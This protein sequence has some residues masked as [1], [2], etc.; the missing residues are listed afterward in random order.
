MDTRQTSVSRVKRLMNRVDKVREYMVTLQ[1]KWEELKEEAHGIAE[2]M[3][4]ELFDD[5]VS[6]IV[7]VPA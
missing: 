7:D 2:S 6:T 4:P 1:E 5:D 3:D